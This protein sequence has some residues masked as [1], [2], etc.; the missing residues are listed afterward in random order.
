MYPRGA[1]GY[2]LLKSVTKASQSLSDKL[3]NSKSFE[4]FDNKLK[5]NNNR[6]H[7]SGIFQNHLKV[8]EVVDKVPV[9]HKHNSTDLPKKYLKDVLAILKY[10]HDRPKWLVEVQDVIRNNAFA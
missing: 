1:F 6:K 5:T 8:T 9:I 2:K 3:L 10:D 4:T 7:L